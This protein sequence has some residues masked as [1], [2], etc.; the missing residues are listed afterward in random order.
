MV[1]RL[2]VIIS[3]CMQISNHHVIYLKIIYCKSTTILKVNHYFHIELSTVLD[4]N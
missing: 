3:L 4:I 1:T 2:T